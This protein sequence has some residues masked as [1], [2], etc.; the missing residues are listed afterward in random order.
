MVRA[1]GKGGL[2]AGYLNA[3]GQLQQPDTRDWVPERISTGPALANPEAQGHQA[4]EEAAPPSGLVH[5]A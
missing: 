3:I 5:M 2:G 4:G 1:Q